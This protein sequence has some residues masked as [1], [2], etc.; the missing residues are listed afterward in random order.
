MKKIKKTLAIEEEKYYNNCKSGG[1]RL[2]KV[3]ETT[4]KVDFLRRGVKNVYF[5]NQYNHSIDAKN[6]LFIP[7]KFRE[8]LG[9]D[10]I[11]I[12]GPEKCLYIYDQ[13]TFDEL[14]RQFASSHDR[15]TQR[16]FFGHASTK[17]PD[18]QGRIT[19]E[20]NLVEYAELK[21][22]AV[23][24]GSGRRIE[25]WAAENFQDEMPDLYQIEGIDEFLF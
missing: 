3:Y 14:G 17:T 18:K 23:L 21:K 16:A 25:I 11:I 5:T 15:K 20:P 22:D 13:E 10:F 12:K 9:E 4:E 1:N 24:V 8:H 7:A 6:R 2:K 19:L